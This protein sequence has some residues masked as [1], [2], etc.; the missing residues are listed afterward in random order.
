MVLPS[1]V[2]ERSPSRA[3]QAQL[4]AW[5]V[6]S[7]FALTPVWWLLGL[8]DAIWIVYGLIMAVL[9]VLSRR[10]TAP[11]SLVVWLIFIGFMFASATQLGRANGSIVVFSYRAALY[12]SATVLL[13]YVY[14]MPEA[15]RART[16]MIAFVAY[17]GWTAAGGLL[18]LARP[19]LQIKTPLYYL[20]SAISPGLLNNPFL[21]RMAIRRAVQVPEGVNYLGEAPRPSAPFVYT[22]NWGNIYSLLLPVVVAYLVTRRRR[23]PAWWLLTALA[24]V[25]LAPAFLTLNRGMFIGL[26]LSAVIIA[27]RLAVGRNYKGIL[28]VGL[29][30]LLAVGAWFVLPVQE[31]LDTRLQGDGTS[32]R[33]SVY[34]QAL[35]KASESPLLGFGVPVPSEIPNEPAI[36]TQ[37]QFWM[38]LVPHGIFATVAFIGFFLVVAWSTWRYRDVVSIAVNTLLV[39]ATIELAFYGVIPYGL[40]IMM[41]AA[42]LISAGPVVQ[43]RGV[44]GSQRQVSLG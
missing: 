11:T 17:W 32:T 7:L 3:W 29:G 8:L 26:G 18:A 20:L 39:V 23:G 1:A 5:P 36:G 27:A 16:A 14:N 35:E 25:S 40:P 4:P 28:L 44:Q 9:L 2:S 43:S 15:R 12:V 30:A 33:A 22:N 34:D 41:V 13:L 31:R 10:T 19:E 37:G 42:G 38:L 21:N 6:T 24:I